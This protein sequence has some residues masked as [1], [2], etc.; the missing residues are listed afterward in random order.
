ME[1]RTVRD[2]KVLLI[3]AVEVTRLIDL[4]F[5]SFIQLC[6]KTLF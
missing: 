4:L 1:D 6:I 2:L 3:A 5:C